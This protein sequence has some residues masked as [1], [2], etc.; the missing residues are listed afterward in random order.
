MS[1]TLGAG[2]GAGGK[3]GA[4]APAADKVD[5]EIAAAIAR[6]NRRL[7]DELQRRKKKPA[8]IDM[9]VRGLGL[10]WC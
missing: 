10:R 1:A 6:E 5:K 7:Q 3:A 8:F 9:M 2:A 4:R